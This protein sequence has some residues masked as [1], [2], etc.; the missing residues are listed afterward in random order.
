MQT[1]K[2]VVAILLAI[3]ASLIGGCMLPMMAGMHATGM[4]QMMHAG[5][6][7]DGMPQLAQKNNCTACHAIDKQ[8]VGPAW[9]DVAKRYKGQTRYSYMGKEYE[10]KEGLMMK[11]SQGGMGNWGTVAMPASDPAR[12][13][14]ADIGQLI[15]FVLALEG[16]T[17][18][19]H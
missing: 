10:L 12:T 2:Y 4:H 6:N 19:K 5:R 17:E 13:P 7:S 11:V 9:A 16:T 14:R 1:S 15:D 18:H 3:A 8:I